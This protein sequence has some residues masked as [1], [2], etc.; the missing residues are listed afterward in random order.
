MD[1]F[2]LIRQY[3]TAESPG[4]G[5]LVGVGDD[6]AVMRPEAGRDL[7]SVIDTLVEGVHYPSDLDATDIGYR[8]VV[9]NLSDIAA[10]AARPR[11]MTLALT[12]RDVDQKWLA[13]FSEG[14]FAAAD[15]QDVAL[16]G[17]DTTRGEQTVISVQITGDLDPNLVLTRSGAKPGDSIYV[18]G[19]PG[20]AAAGLKLMQRNIFSAGTGVRL[21][22]KFCHPVARIEL[23][24]KIAPFATAAIDVSDG[25][26][27]DV[28]KLLRASSLGGQI[29]IDT[30]PLSTEIIEQF[31]VDQA[32]LFALGGGDDYELCFTLAA[33]DETLLVD[34]ITGGKVRITRI[35]TVTEGGGLCCRQA[36]VM[37]DYDDTGYLHF[38]ELGK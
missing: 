12:L 34:D 13:G 22:D 11:W 18:S 16:V 3:F 26:Y 24:Q 9:V 2:E 37:F 14:L 32:R 30:L 38:G 28:Q 21:T 4:S 5:V 35:G 17:G 33:E 1:E 15:E 36:G 10:M 19:T 8:A 25:L 7:V 31:G 29:D 23:A 20:D 27:A 6:G